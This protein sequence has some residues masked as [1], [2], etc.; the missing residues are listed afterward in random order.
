MMDAAEAHELAG[1]AEAGRAA[2][3]M[4]Q[5]GAEKLVEEPYPVF[6]RG[7]VSAA[8]GDGEWPPDE[9]EQ[10]KETDTALGHALPPDELNHAWGQGATMSR[11]QARIRPVVGAANRATSL[12]ER[13][14]MPRQI[15][16]TP[17]APSSPL[18]SQGVKAGSQLFIAG[19]TGIDPST[20]DL[21]GIPSN[22]RRAR[23]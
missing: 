3:R 10:Y 12:T 22:S 7:G 8:S 1:L 23:R 13:T 11:K 16:A 2:A 5:P 9:L 20:G 15:I 21:A 17:D 14:E 19:T 4:H 18:Y 6:G